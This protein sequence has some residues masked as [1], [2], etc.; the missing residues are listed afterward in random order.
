MLPNNKHYKKPRV[1]A[2]F[3]KY[4]RQKM[5]EIRSYELKMQQ[6][7][8]LALEATELRS[9]LS[10][11][12]NKLE[13]LLPYAYALVCETARRFLI[14]WPH[15]TQVMSAI[16]LHFG[17]V[18]DMQNGEGKTLV[19]TMPL[20]LNSLA[21]P[22]VHL[23]TSNSYLA[24][25]DGLWM[26]P[27]FKSLGLN[28][29]VVLNDGAFHVVSGSQDYDLEP[30]IRQ[31]AYGCDVVYLTLDALIFDYLKD[32]IVKP[33][34]TPVQRSLSYV[35]VDEV[36][37]NLI[38]RANQPWNMTRPSKSFSDQAYQGFK[39]VADSLV[40]DED[41]K[42]SE[43]IVKF[44]ERG[45]NKLDSF[46]N[47]KPIFSE[48][49]PGIAKQIAQAL[50]AKEKY[51]EGVNYV[52]RDGKAVLVDE[53]TH[54]L[55]PN[56][57]EY[58]E[59]LQQAIQTKENLSI[60]PQQ[61]TVASI[62]TQNFFKLYTHMAG[63]SGTAIDEAHELATVYNLNVFPV[64]SF[65]EYLSGL[66]GSELK[67]KRNKD[68]AGEYFTFVRLE[69]EQKPIF[70]KR[71]DYMDIIFRTSEARMR[72]VVQSV[73]R[74][75]CLGQPILIGTTSVEMSE[76]MSLLLSPTL[77]R[78]LVR[79]L[80]LREFWFK[81]NNWEDDGRKRDQLVPL[82]TPLDRI[83]YSVILRLLKDV[84][85]KANDFTISLG[86]KS[87][88][89]I[90]QLIEILGLEKDDIQRLSIILVTGIPHNI[91]NAKNHE[92][93]A[94][95]IKD[96][97]Q[98]GAVT[99][100]TNVAGL[101]VDIKLGGE[102]PQSELFN[103]TRILITQRHDATKL[104]IDEKLEMLAN[105]PEDVR[106]SKTEILQKLETYANERTKVRSLDGLAVYGIGRRISRR[107]DNQLR[108]RA[109]RQGDPGETRFYLSLQDELMMRQ[110]GASVS[111]LMQTLHV[112]DS[113]PLEAN[114]VGRVIEN[115]QIRMENSDRAVRNYV[116]EYDYVLDSKR[117]K[118]YWARDELFRTEEFSAEALQV[119]KDF[120]QQMVNIRL[121]GKVDETKL[122]DLHGFLTKNFQLV[123]PQS[124][125][126]PRQSKDL[127][128]Q[129]IYNALEEQYQQI[130]VLVGK[131][132][133]NVQRFLMIGALD[134]SW[135][136]FLHK[137]EVIRSN[138]TLLAYSETERLAWFA[139]EME[140]LYKNF[141][142]DLNSRFVIALMR[143]PVRQ[144][145]ADI[146][147]NP[148][149]V[150][151]ADNMVNLEQEA[152]RH[153]SSMLHHLGEDASTISDLDSP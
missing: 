16:A 36:D 142:N 133:A 58:S 86:L 93:E 6:I 69:N 97:G 38:D 116:R 66:P 140:E 43:W 31:I 71:R 126:L 46:F 34:Q 118:V 3:D 84:Q 112:D 10:T 75:Y 117:K 141:I 115:S 41:Y 134:E 103:L 111:N 39:V 143:L 139:Q 65:V 1:P 25:R 107:L 150:L 128:Q 67:M 13:S 87:Q 72:F 21:L 100:V 99:I 88:R 129:L 77:I 98:L 96:A 11:D 54:F 52:I 8:D 136:Q 2:R 127:I 74:R 145:I 62:T 89:N 15:D 131:S 135:I 19:A 12:K 120:T 94:L 63:M 91:L 27:I 110:G 78:K 123:F 40:I 148:R 14:L 70:F 17:F 20:F 23:V 22:S 79:V 90:D 108:G 101:G 9:K 82:D 152:W 64:P 42:I 85:I 44:T 83:D 37:V 53:I 113:L 26:A 138:L 50:L 35:I 48:K 119:I 49:Y 73:V 29:G 80:L 125:V 32:H 5:E 47:V 153:L 24:K 60:S 151:A 81:V 55:L 124:F 144:P 104:S 51:K 28:I 95:I 33:P 76:K 121:P 56:Q 114:F 18:V 149:L 57:R 4:V 45:V 146:S 30:C 105:L 68:A 147:Q 132:F 61:Q 59:G 102:P 7:P 130:A 92:D 122:S 137:A 106:Q 109:A